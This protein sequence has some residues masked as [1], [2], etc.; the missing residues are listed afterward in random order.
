MQGTE[1]LSVEDISDQER[2]IACGR[3]QLR[4]IDPSV[5]ASRF[6]PIGYVHPPSSLPLSLSPS[7]I[8]YLFMFL[9]L[10]I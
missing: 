6:P 5:A 2:Y 3:E 1:V 9:G 7:L 10:W 4:A 8:L